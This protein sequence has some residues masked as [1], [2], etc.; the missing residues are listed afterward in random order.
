MSTAA[1]GLTSSPLLLSS[2]TLP[3]ERPGTARSTTTAPRASTS[4]PPAPPPW[5]CRTGVPVKKGKGSP[6]HLT[7]APVVVA[8]P[9]RPGHSH[10]PEQAEPAGAATAEVDATALAA[11]TTTLAPST[12][13]AAAAIAKLQPPPPPVPS[14]PLAAAAA[15]T[16]APAA[17]PRTV[18]RPSRAATRSG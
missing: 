16:A 12:P 18:A 15:A 5:R 4:Q 7:T 13:A 1:H 10:G 9:P 8:L 11:T 2:A 6:S 17:P 3:P 14:A